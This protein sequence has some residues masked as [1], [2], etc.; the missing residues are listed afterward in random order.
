MLLLSFIG[1]PHCIDLLL[2]FK[3]SI[4]VDHTKTAEL[5][6][7][8]VYR[9]SA[10]HYISIFPRGSL[11]STMS[12][13]IALVDIVSTRSDATL[14]A[15]SFTEPRS[16]DSY[17]PST[18]SQPAS[19]NE[20]NEVVVLHRS[21]LVAMVTQLNLIGAMASVVTGLLT[22]ALPRIAQDLDLDREL[23]NW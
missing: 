18:Y 21:A 2:C 15:A 7:S 11:A 10:T 13:T 9:P 4:S 22:I 6:L 17:A 1:I 23:L 20:R 19:Q 3:K 8:E 16:L 14:R 5:E 12:S